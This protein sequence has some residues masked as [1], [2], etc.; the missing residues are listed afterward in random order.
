MSE[1]C[2][3][4]QVVTEDFATWKEIYDGNADYRVQSG[5]NEIFLFQDIN[6]KNSVTLLFEIDDI[7]QTKEYFNSPFIQEKMRLGKVLGEV[8]FTFLKKSL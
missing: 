2:V 1:I 5:I 8:Q 4:L 7:D 3:L 6:N